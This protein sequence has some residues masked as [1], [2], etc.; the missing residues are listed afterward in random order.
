M[1]G[2]C[3]TETLRQGF[4]RIDVLNK[5]FDVKYHFIHLPEKHL[6]EFAAKDIETCDILLVQDNRLW[7][8]FPL[9]DCVR[10]GADIRKF[11]LIRFASLWP[12]DAWNG[13]G[14]SSRTHDREAPENLRPF[15]IS[16]ACSA[17]CARRSPTRTPALTP[18]VR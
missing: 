3:Q 18:I 16:T 1:I 10:P 15:P 17:G 7:D 8:E 4:A 12:F 2:N 14:D 6:R 5:M 11:P 13:P 9:R